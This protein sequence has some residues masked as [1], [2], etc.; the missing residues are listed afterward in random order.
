MNYCML[1][2]DNFYS[3]A[4]FHNEVAWPISIVKECVNAEVYKVYLT[5]YK[6]Q[7]KRKSSKR[8]NSARNGIKISLQHRAG[9]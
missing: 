6:A 2:S 9:S 7:R 5:I 3:L 8:Y 4:C 1:K